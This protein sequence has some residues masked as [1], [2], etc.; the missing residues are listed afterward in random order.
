MLAKILL[1]TWIVVATAQAATLGNPDAPQGGTFQYNLETAPTTLHALSATDY[2]ARRVHDY[3]LEGL[4]TRDI[5]TDEWAPALATAWKINKDG[6][7]FEFTLREGAKWHDGKPVTVEDV[8]FS[9]DAI[10]HPENKYKTA[11]A[12]PY[13]EDIEL[14]EIVDAKTVRFKTKR[15]YFKNFEVA[16]GLTVIPKHIYE[17]PSKEQEKKLNKTVI[18]SGAY[19]LTKYDRTKGIELTRN[20][21][22]WGNNVPENKGENNVEKVQMKFV[23]DGTIALTMLEK[24]ELDF[25]P[26]Q[27]E[28]YVQKAKGAKWGKSVFKVQSENKGPK[29]YAFLG[30]NLKDTKFQSKKTRLALYHLVNRP[31]MN[32]KFMFSMSLMAT[33]PLYIQSEYANQ[34]V[35]QVDFDPKKALELLKDDGWSDSDGDQILDKTINGS[36]TKLSFTILE[37]SQDFVKFLTVFKEDA[38][39]A[40]VEIN[41]KYIEWNSFLKLVDERKFEAIRLAWGGGSLDWDPKQ[42]WHSSSIGNEGSNFIGYSNPDVDKMIDQAREEMDKKKRIKLMQKIYKDIADDVPYIF[43]FNPKYALY[44]HTEK[45]KRVKDTYK[46]GIG[47]NYWWISK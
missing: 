3:I 6:T 25:L 38:K 40:G 19:K 11:H 37:P 24:G 17:N 9:F 8:K 26:M 18:G 32:E 39:K 15:K 29:G 23:Q 1:M 2:Y 10:V 42:I 21:E 12:K 31:L 45:M 28:D 5:E 41:I 7:E 30:F 43:F 46:F 13:Y 44:G 27:P 34:N 47:L 4:L 20:N 22:W 16:A 36:K 33:G 35:K 14:V